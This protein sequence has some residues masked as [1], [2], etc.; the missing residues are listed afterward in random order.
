MIIL[1]LERA[2]HIV[3]TVFVIFEVI[4]GYRVIDVLTQNQVS[5]F[6]LRQLEDFVEFQDIPEDT[7][8]TNEMFRLER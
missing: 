6:H 1:P 4:Q 2:V 7:E 8:E 3:L 5:K